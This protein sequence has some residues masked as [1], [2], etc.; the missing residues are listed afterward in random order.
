[1]EIK[2][3]TIAEKAKRYDEVIPQLKGL[4][5]G[6]HEEKCDIMEED[7]LKIF[8][9]L[10][11]NEDERIRKWLI[12]YFKE[13]CDNVSEKE[14]KG[15]LAYLEKQSEQKPTDKIEPKFRKG[16]WIV[17]NGLTLYVKEVVK[18]FYITVSNGG[19]TNGYD[20]NIDNIARLWTI[21]DAKDGDVLF[22][23]LMGGKTFIYNGV[24]LDMAILYS[25][26]ISND[27]EDVLP[28]H[29]GKPNTGIGNIEENKNIIHPATKEQRD[30]LFQKMKE[31]G[32]EWNDEK[33][34]LKKI[35][36]EVNAEDYGIDGLY[37]AQR[38]LEKTLGKVEGYQTDDGILDHKAAITTIKK[39]YEQKSAKWSE[40]DAEMIE[41]L[42]NCLGQL[43]LPKGRGLPQSR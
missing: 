32:Y 6:I 25:F 20:W 42:N 30:L 35:Y 27:S 34:E 13:V 29:I 21:E 18:G 5:D 19:T 2:K 26:I 38:I 4:L 23:D 7:I 3:L 12:Y 10:K 9:E 17:F 16:D 43:P 14:K 39:L 8:H 22:Q 31:A 15:V 41:G 40:E 24:N 36:K 11:E 1:M 33:K 28:Y 37:H